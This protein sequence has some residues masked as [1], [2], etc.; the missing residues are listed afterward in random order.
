MRV[1]SLMDALL[2][3]IEKFCR[4]RV[5]DALQNSILLQRAVAIA[6]CDER[7]AEVVMGRSVIGLL[8]DRDLILLDRFAVTTQLVKRITELVVCFRIVGPQLDR[9]AQLFD[10]FAVTLEIVVT[11]AEVVL[12]GRVAGTKCQSCACKPSRLLRTA[13]CCS[14]RRRRGRGAR[15]P[16][17]A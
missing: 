4:A 7:H 2:D 14:N 1:A 10:G 5:V 11:P 3:L 17:R 15:G 13:S 16:C 9:F 12:S 6:H 8:L